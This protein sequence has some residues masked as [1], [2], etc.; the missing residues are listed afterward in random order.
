MENK[1]Y[2]VT[3]CNDC[4]VCSQEYNEWSTGDDVVVYCMLENAHIKSYHSH[5]DDG[6][7]NTPDWCP[8]NKQVITIKKV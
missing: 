2:K 7:I 5:L 4:P 6:D 3:G 8:L 1:E